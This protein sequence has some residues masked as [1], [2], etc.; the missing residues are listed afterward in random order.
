VIGGLAVCLKLT[1]DQS[2]GAFAVL[3]MTVPP[4]FA[5]FGPHRHAATTELYYLTSGS[6]AFTLREETVIARPGSF[7][8]V[9]PGI[10]HRFW[11][12]TA[13]PASCLTWLTPGGSEQYFV[14]L[15]ALAAGQSQWPP[16]ESNQLIALGRDYDHDFVGPLVDG[17]TQLKPI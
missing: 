8:Q 15:A 7:V 16:V 11:N 12:P 3:E 6:L 13:T 17:H 2:D 1:G 14:Q 5:G 10:V 4:Y 9:A